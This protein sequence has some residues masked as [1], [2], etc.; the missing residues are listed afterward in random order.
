MRITHT[1]MARHSLAD[2]TARATSLD[3]A[4]RE[5]SS[6]KRI[7]QPSDDPVGTQRAILARAELAA[8]AQYQSN[9]DHATGFLQTTDTALGEMTDLLHRARELLVRA[10]N[11]VTDQASRENIAL[12]V[13]QIVAQLK[14]AANTTYGGV[15]LFG[16]TATTTRPYDTT[17]TPP[18]DTYAGD[19]NPLAREIGPGVSVQIN[20]IVGTGTPPLVGQGGGDGGLIDS[21]RT[22]AA[23]LRAGTAAASNALKTSDLQA[24]D[25]NLDTINAARS[26]VGATL[27]RLSA[28]SDRL[29]ANE[30]ATTDLLSKTEDVDFAQATI[31]LSTQQTVYQAALHVGANIIQPSLLD[32]LR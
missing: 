9:I 28:A 20:T 25:G 24:L 6:Q 10:A 23:N 4:M 2:I 11:D 17:T 12:E 31:E 26:N 19:A 14:T 30:E 29:A 3:R 18:V 27:N 13:D 32:F 1:M 22:I 8:N 5:L 21:L 16:G 15:Y 7:L